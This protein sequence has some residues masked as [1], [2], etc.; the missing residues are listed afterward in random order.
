MA[1][2]IRILMQTTIPA[3]KDD[4]HIG[5]FS[6]LQAHLA[7]LKDDLGNPLYHVTA[8]DRAT[9]A[10]EN[11][12]VLSTL[13]R[14]HFDELW[15]F[16]VDVGNGLTSDECQAIETFQQ[17]G[18]GV[19]AARDHQDLGS[20]LC[21][22]AGLGAVNFFHSRNPDP[23]PTRCCIDDVYTTNISWPNYHSGRN[24]DSQ[25]ITPT[26]PLH[27]L[28]QN[29]DAPSGRIEFFPAHPHEGGI[30]IALGEPHAQVIATGKSII[31]GRSFNLAIAFDRSSETDKRGRAVA[32]STFHHFCDYNWNPSLGCPSFVS[33]LPG[34][35]IAEAPRV[36][37]DIHTYIRNLSLWLAPI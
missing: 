29:P 15:L 37:Q 30:G 3:I 33:E 28:L 12:P 18:G 11:D 34:N 5:R 23:D 8:R 16:A 35:G 2:P 7:S 22:I 1:N 26:Q 36:L 14:T 27:D 19:L 32:A 21:H 13:D 9:G 31:S 20:S 17:H 10:S 25:V 6:L 4:W 24:G